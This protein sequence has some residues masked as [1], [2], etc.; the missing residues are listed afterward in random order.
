MLRI[1]GYYLYTIGAGIHPLSEIQPNAAF[2]DWAFVI[3][4]AQGTLEPFLVNSVYQHQVSGNA[5]IKLLNLIK[6]LA[7]DPKRTQPITPGEAYEIRTAVTEFENV[8]T[9]EFRL[10]NLYLV[11]KK[12][13]YDTQDLIHSGIVLFP[14][15]LPSKVPECVNDINSATRC[16]AF[17]LPT[18][19]AFHLHRATEAV[20]HRYF[21]AVAGGKIAR[22]TS[23]NIGEYLKV[24]R[25]NKLGEEKLLASL[26]DIKDLYR[27]PVVHPE[28]SLESIDEAI[29]LL[30]S[31]H[32]AV[33][34]M[35]K[36]IPMPA[37]QQTLA[38]PSSA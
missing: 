6:Q 10:A 8:L 28:D 37:Q 26:R 12:R 31:L 1:D 15:D 11:V 32:A 22:P 5:G 27:N 19:A 38:V 33:F 3:Y 29:A 36:A 17:E 35:L 9:A 23:R 4:I 25:D 13:G 18:A 34:G 30:G 21:D 2:A 20:L 24:L 14:H 7:S 16:I